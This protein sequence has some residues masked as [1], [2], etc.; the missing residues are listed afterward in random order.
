MK[1]ELARRLHFS[2]AQQQGIGS[3]RTFLLEEL[4]MKKLVLGISALA[5]AASAAFAAEGD[6][7]KVAAAADTASFSK[8]DAD[9]DGRVSAIE[10]ANDT[11]IAASFTAADADKDGYLSKEEFSMAGKASSD[12]GATPRSDSSAPA[13][14]STTPP[15]DTSAPASPPQQ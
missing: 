3:S 15:S 1:T 4:I 14:E 12:S 6:D 2:P 11:K 7:T 9:A 8:L 10:A 5:L 13:G